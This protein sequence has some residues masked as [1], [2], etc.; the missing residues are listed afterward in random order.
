MW[1]EVLGSRGPISRFRKA[2]S[3]GATVEVVLWL[4][5]FTLLMGIIVDLSLIFGGQSEIL[6][7]VQDSNRS[8]SVG[9]FLT[10]QEAQDYI[11]AEVVH[12]APT[13]SVTIKVV[14]G[15]IHTDVI[16]PAR[17]LTAT[18]LFR[19]FDDLNIVISAEHLTET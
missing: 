4:P 17:D 16:V 11:E 14:S 8:L 3:G 7:I 18:G 5:F 10:I 13:A 1:S 2:E 15:V 12:L 19:G 9:K 6:R